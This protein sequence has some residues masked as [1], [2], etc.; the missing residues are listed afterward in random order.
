[1]TN[2][3]NKQLSRKSIIKAVRKDEE[4][5]YLFR[6]YIAQVD[7]EFEYEEALE[8]CNLSDLRE[9]YRAYRSK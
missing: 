5:F 8:E 1:M 3:A 2:N 4:F 6:E 9:L 7:F